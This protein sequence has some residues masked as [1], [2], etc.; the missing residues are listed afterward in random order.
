[1]SR[2]LL[3][4]ALGPVQ[5]FIFQARRTRDMW[6]GSHIL[7]EMSRGVAR[8]LAKDG[9]TLVFPALSH[10][11]GELALSEH[12]RRRGGAPPLAISNIILAVSPGLDEA[13]LQA[14]AEK[15]RLAAIDV[16]HVFA[17]RAYGAAAP[18]LRGGQ[19]DR[20]LRGAVEGLLECVAAW[21]PLPDE[22]SAE[23]LRAAR[24]EVG[25]AVAARKNLR[26]F[27]AWAGVAGLPK[28]SL[29]GFRETALLERQAKE[30]LPPAAADVAAR[31]RI[32]RNEQLDA[33]GLVK[34]C[35]GRPDQFVPLARI[36]LQPWIAAV[37]EAELARANRTGLPNRWH[38]MVAAL[39]TIKDMTTLAGI[40]RSAVGWLGDFPFD[41]E[42]FLEDQWPN[43]PREDASDKDK[44]KYETFVQGLVGPLLRRR[45]PS[46]YIACLVADGD[47]MGE[48]LDRIAQGEG[49]DPL[50]QL[51]AASAGIAGFAQAVRSIVEAHEGALVFAGGD[52]VLAFLPVTR[53][54]ACADALRQRFSLDM[55]NAF[56]EPF[57]PPRPTLSVGIGVGHVLEP[58]RELIERARR[59][60][61]IAKRGPPREEL[62]R[63]RQRNAL[64]VVSARRGG[65]EA[66]L[67]RQWSED[68]APMIREA[69]LTFLSEDANVPHGLPY[70][71]RDLLNRLPR[72][73]RADG[74]RTDLGIG[75]VDAADPVWAAILQGEM[76]RFL[77]QKRVLGLSG[78]STS[79]E[80]DAA[81]RTL[82]LEL[83][84]AA[85]GGV[86]DSVREWV[87]IALVIRH[88]ALAERAC[89]FDRVAEVNQP[90]QA[91][92]P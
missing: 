25:A 61:G 21:T 80:V 9:F 4:V 11:D 12:M 62:A 86:H 24:D 50:R 84:G 32:P 64:A 92:Q 27:K 23:D 68:P 35:G 28:S 70:A 67:R 20:S 39:D 79:E 75:E 83:A 47:R 76:R 58:M 31:Y 60:E 22:A 74:A 30:P 2:F 36:A 46:P 40:D 52:D 19:D 59:A 85:Y 78:S 38:S 56:P 82:G 90:E 17:T 3:Q 45:T 37:R 49:I 43:H 81:W 10:G 6:F 63:D 77:I 54:V 73:S 26:D 72:P 13:T 1:M 48:A 51:V 65:A 55:V 41:G 16:W 33:V 8:Q 14:A 29:D 69:L 7:S 66:V 34:R 44:A 15:A 91:V 87:D 5:D 42:L 88:F 53:A 57:Q 18:L 71:V 89:R